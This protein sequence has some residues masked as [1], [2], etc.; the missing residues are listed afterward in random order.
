MII[1]FIGKCIINLFNVIK[2]LLKGELNLR[3]AIE[4]AAVIGYDSLPISLIITF[5]A[6]SVLSLQ[7]AKYFVMSGAEAY[8]GGLVSVALV[9]EMAPIFASLAIG[10]RAGTAIAAEI[11]NMK[12]TEQID[13]MKTLRVDPMSYILLPRILAGI[14]MV[15]LVTILSELI[16]ILGGMF[17][18]H[19]TIA[20]HFKR[21]LNSVWLYLS[22]HDIQVSLIKAVV[23]GLI[24]TLICSTQGY[25]TEGGAKEVGISTTKAAIY[26]TFTILL[27]DYF[28]TWIFFS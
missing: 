14:V 1:S 21:Y 5:I 6:G 13:A 11:G 23:F 2:S 16:G 19:L 25:E 20:L 18:S 7:I 17:I 24:I 15:P 4:Q 27:F 10:A 9:R 26:T 28:L 8:V 22:I 12:V 3:H